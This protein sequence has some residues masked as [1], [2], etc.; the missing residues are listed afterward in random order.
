MFGDILGFVSNIMLCLPNAFLQFC[1]VCKVLVF[2]ALMQTFFWLFKQYCQS[3]VEI[4]LGSWT[5]EGR[6]RWRLFVFWMRC[7]K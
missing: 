3:I 2:L 5:V 7:S 6:G 4:L 1:V